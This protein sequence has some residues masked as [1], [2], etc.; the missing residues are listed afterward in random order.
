M[1]YGIKTIRLGVARFQYLIDLT[2]LSTLD[3]VALA[4]KYQNF[5]E[6]WVMLRKGTW[7]C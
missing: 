4:N 5:S 2:H 1:Y 3:S 6:L 7:V